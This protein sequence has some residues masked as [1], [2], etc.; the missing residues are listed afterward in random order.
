MNSNMFET[1]ESSAVFQSLARQKDYKQL[2]YASE[3]M[4]GTGGFGNS[5]AF[6]TAIEGACNVIVPMR[7]QY[8]RT[9]LMELSMVQENLLRL[10]SIAETIGYDRLSMMCWTEREYILE[11]L[12]KLTGNRMMLSMCCPGGVRR[13]LDMDIISESIDEID[14]VI[15]KTKE[16]Y[17][18]FESDKQI[19]N[20]LKGLGYLSK[21][22][23][24]AAS[25]TGPGA[26]GSGLAED[27]RTLG[28]Y[29]IYHLLGF[30]PVVEQ[31]GDCYARCIVKVRE[32]IQ[33]AEL[34]KSAVN[35]M[36]EGSICTQMPDRIEGEW[37][38]R[39]E[40]ADGM[41]TYYVKGKGSAFLEDAGIRKAGESNDKIMYRV[42]DY[43]SE[44]EALVRLTLGIDD[45]LKER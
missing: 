22:E 13:D 6:C 39:I 1:T 33:S 30:K 5:F 23:A 7:A 19:M 21:E 18:I 35:E 16:I 26:K 9:I 20:R 3:R 38:A 44:D 28:E 34:V 40:Q 37:I 4:Y 10:A 2:V 24:E 36:P 43:S 17:E 45:C 14:N 29:G 15:L 8:I 32:I 31:G 42:T 41:D 11:I 25:V 12:E 27:R